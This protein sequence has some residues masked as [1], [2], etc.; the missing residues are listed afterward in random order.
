MGAMLIGDSINNNIQ[1]QFRGILIE[2][3]NTETIQLKVIYDEE[4]IL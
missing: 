4:P 1:K 2:R 3:A